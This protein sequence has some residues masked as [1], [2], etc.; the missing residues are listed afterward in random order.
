MGRWIKLCNE[1][2]C[3][4]RSDIRMIK[5]MRTREGGNVANVVQNRKQTWISF[6]NPEGTHNWEDPFTN[7]TVLN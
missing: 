7:G 5:H 3:L 6:V 4:Y 1:G 2:K